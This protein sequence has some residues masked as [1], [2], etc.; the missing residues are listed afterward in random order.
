MSKISSVDST[1]KLSRT[2]S[3][4]TQF[5][6]W[7]QMTVGTSAAAVCAV[8]TESTE[9]SVVKHEQQALERVIDSSVFKECVLCCAVVTRNT[10]SA[11]G[12]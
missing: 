9:V 8:E 2:L 12:D 11:L 10:F 5:R 1:E 3:W 7:S 4:S 6:A